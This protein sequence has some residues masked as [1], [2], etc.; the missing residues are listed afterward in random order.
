V[1]NLSQGALESIAA[2][3]FFTVEVFTLRGLVTHYVLF[4]ATRVAKEV[5][6]LS[7]AKLR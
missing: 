7:G 5:P 4:S 6:C 2:T 1:V 3:D